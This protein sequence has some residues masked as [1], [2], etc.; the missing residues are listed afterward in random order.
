VA[1][2][3]AMLIRLVVTR[4]HPIPVVFHWVLAGY[5]FTLGRQFTPVRRP[6]RLPSTSAVSGG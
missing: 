4:S 1:Y 3:L 5:L 2:A 6:A